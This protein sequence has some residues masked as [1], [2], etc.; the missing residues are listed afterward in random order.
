MDN[1]TSHLLLPFLPSQ[2]SAIADSNSR[3]P[4]GKC[5]VKSQIDFSENIKNKS[6]IYSTAGCINKAEQRTQKTNIENNKNN[7]RKSEKTK[8]RRQTRILCFDCEAT[9]MR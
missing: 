1:C 6:K 9:K 2:A 4:F 7:K 3:R 5:G 8:V